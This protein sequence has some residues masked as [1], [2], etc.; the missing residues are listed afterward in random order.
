MAD[1]VIVIEDA[2]ATAVGAAA[3]PA[4]APAGDDGDDEVTAL[5]ARGGLDLPHARCHCPAHAF[6]AGPQ[7]HA[8]TC[9][10][11]YCWVCDVAASACL[12]WASHCHAHDRD[13]GWRALRESVRARARAGGSRA[14]SA[15]SAASAAPAPAAAGPRVCA[16]ELCGRLAALAG[17]GEGA[18]RET[19]I[20]GLSF[21][22]RSHAM[23]VCDRRFGRELAYSILSSQSGLRVTRLRAAPPAAQP[24]AQPAAEPS[25]RVAV[26]LN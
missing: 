1:D 21:E 26:Y 3:A 22:A 9:A 7:S 24:A 14:A 6:G 13:E 18:P 20:A 10:R 4:T 16:C 17:G 11:C 23:G 2:R 15:A 8:R 25:V 19:V 5:G 12:E